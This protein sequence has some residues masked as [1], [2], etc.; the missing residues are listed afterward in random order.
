MA[1]LPFHN[2]DGA[3]FFN[4]S[5]RSL[6]RYFCDIDLLYASLRITPLDFQKIAQ[7]IYYLD[8]DTASLWETI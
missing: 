4:G 5:P 7:M 3:P 2:E 6:L 8:N 1:H